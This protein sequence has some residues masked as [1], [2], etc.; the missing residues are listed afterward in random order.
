MADHQTTISEFGSGRLELSARAL[1]ALHMG[2]ITTIQ[3]ARDLGLYGLL[4]LPHMGRKWAEEVWQ[5][6]S[7][8]TTVPVPLWA[9]RF[10]LDNAVLQDEGPTGE[11]W[12]SS[13]MRRALGALEDAIRSNGTENA[14]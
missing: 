2:G 9:L 11:G 13:E 5:A 10:V 7:G 4:R 1:N 6:V 3:Q 12:P 14:Q 8:P